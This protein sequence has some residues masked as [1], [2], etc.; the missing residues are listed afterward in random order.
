MHAQGHANT[1]KKF[2]LISTLLMYLCLKCCGVVMYNKYKRKSDA[3][4]A[5]AKE[6]GYFSFS[7]EAI[8]D[9]KL[10]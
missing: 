4:T 2:L 5:P 6:K 1:H 7:Q 9:I 8:V 10:C 3:Q